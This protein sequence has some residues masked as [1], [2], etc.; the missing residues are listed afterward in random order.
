MYS[1]DIVRKV[2]WRH[3]NIMIDQTE[4]PIQEHLSYSDKLEEI[5]Y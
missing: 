1:I 3:L 4:V 5:E 2:L